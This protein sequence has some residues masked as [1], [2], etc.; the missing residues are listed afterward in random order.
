MDSPIK[1]EPV[2]MSIPIKKTPQKRE[3]VG[4]WSSAESYLFESLL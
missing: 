2:E 3:K 1:L 4:R